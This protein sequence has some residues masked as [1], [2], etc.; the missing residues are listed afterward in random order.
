M[1]YLCLENRNFSLK[2]PDK[3]KISSE[4]CLQKSTFFWTLLHNP[5]RFRTILTPLHAVVCL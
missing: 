4:I 1:A 2:L 5:P 3:I